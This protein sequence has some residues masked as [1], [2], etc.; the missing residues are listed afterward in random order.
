MKLK[1]QLAV[2]VLVV[3]LVLAGCSGTDTQTSPIETTTDGQTIDTKTTDEQ[4]ESTN[5]KKNATIEN[6]TETNKQPCEQSPS[7]V[8]AATPACNNTQSLSETETNTDTSTKGET[9]T[10]PRTETRT[11][12]ETTSVESDTPT[13]TQTESPPTRVQT[14]TETR[15]E[16]DCS[17]FSTQAAAQEVFNRHE[18]DIYRLDGDNDGQACESLPSGTGTDTPSD[19]NTNENVVESPI[20]GG[21]ARKAVVTRVID[22]DTVEVRF[23]N[24]EV[25]T[26]RLIGV[27]TPE[28]SVSNQNPSEYGIPDT[29]SGS[30]WLLMW[31]ENAESFANNELAGEEVLVVTD[32]EGDT[33]GY[34]G[35]LLAYVYYSN[36]ENFG[37]VLLE[38]GYARVYTGAEFTLESEYLQIESTAQDANRGL[39][40]YDEEYITPTPTPTPSP[41]PTETSTPTPIPTPSPTETPSEVVTLPLPADGDYDCGHFDTHEQAQE[42]FNDHEDDVY[43][44]DGD[45][46]GQAC[47]SLP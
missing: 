11:R 34:Y 1:Q 35:R 44:L 36:G 33:R 15:I 5:V 22:G 47:E 17:D 6:G 46:D 29:P 18:D 41:V 39:W 19:E 23:A 2:A 16:Y 20:D 7:G 9:E 30:D 43:R 4:T 32:P 14:K 40:A 25:D 27:D 37:H 24:G 42:V 12:V 8:E 26:V 31:G 28:T 21:T 38:R 10:E 13:N 3:C 45:G